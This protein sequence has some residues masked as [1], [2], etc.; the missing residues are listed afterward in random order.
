MLGPLN[1]LPLLLPT[2]VLDPD[3]S[4]TMTPMSSLRYL[5]V[6]EGCTSSI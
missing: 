1:R 6:E 5:L 3:R 4:L 2:M